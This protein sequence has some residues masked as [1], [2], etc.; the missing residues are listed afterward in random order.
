MTSPARLA[1]FVLAA[2][3]AACATTPPGIPMRMTELPSEAP[4]AEQRDRVAG[5]ISFAGGGAGRTAGYGMWR[6]A[7]PAVDLAHAGDGI[8]AGTLSGRPVRLAASPGKLEGA[9]VELYLYQDGETVTLRGLWFQRSIWITMT[10]TQLTGHLAAN[11]PGFD[12]KRDAPDKWSGNWGPG[13]PIFLTFK[14]EAAQY[15]AVATPQFYL[16]LLSALL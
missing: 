13:V 4:T 11:A 2:G 5:E 7:G 9:G 8:W 6:V 16:A 3:L 1:G 10:P 12:I 14:G 15:P